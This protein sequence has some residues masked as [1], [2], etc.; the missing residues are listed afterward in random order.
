MTSDDG[1][2]ILHLEDHFLPYMSVLAQ[3]VGL[4]R[5]DPTAK[6][7]KG[8][9]H[10]HNPAGGLVPFVPSFFRRPFVV[11]RSLIPPGLQKGKWGGPCIFGKTIG[12]VPAILP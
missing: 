9:F 2:S 12:Y 7:S 8:F 4:G 6:V 3:F 10:D 1:S 11:M 5:L